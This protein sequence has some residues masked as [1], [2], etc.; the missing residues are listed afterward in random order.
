MSNKPS[1]L[2]PLLRRVLCCGILI[3]ALAVVGR[4]QG[5][6]GDTPEI[7]TVEVQGVGTGDQATARDAAIQDAQRRAVEVGVGLYIKSE[8]V[9]EN[10]TL[11]S[12]KIYKQAAG[13]V[14]HYDIEE[15]NYKQE[16]NTC[17][18]K[19]KAE[20]SLK[21][22]ADSLDN[23][24]EKLKISGS[25]RFIVMIDESK[26]CVAVNALTSV[27]VDKGFKVLDED[28]VTAQRQKDALRLIHQGKI[29]AETA[30]LLHDK[31]DIVIKGEVSA[32]AAER[33]TNDPATY[34]QTVSIEA[35]IIG[36]DT[37]QILGAKSGVG[38]GVA[39]SEQRA[40]KAAKEKVGDDFLA[41][42]LHT[43]LRT[44]FDP[45]KE[46]T[47]KVADCSYAQMTAVDAKLAAARFT[48]Q[49]DARFED[50]YG[51]ISVLFAG[52][53]K[54]LATHLETAPGIKLRV[55]SV[56]GMTVMVK[57]VGN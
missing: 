21:Q 6:S 22:I 47:V 28:S 48:R 14:H 17:W 33:V 44:I 38:A 16:T 24:Y 54:M 53:A 32:E 57:V 36:V 26:P 15:Q 37:A 1:S 10:L 49:S 5:E 45:C 23:L 46:Y 56:T 20:V 31:A 9:V 43:M 51:V 34:S 40:L 52:T 50:P 7:K 39:Y 4:A 35:K 18:V 41:K 42:N 30:M 3:S 2:L 11:V 27:M 55:V 29:D 13:F 25:P 12:D 8:T 19:I